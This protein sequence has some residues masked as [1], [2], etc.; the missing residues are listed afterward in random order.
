MVIH[1]LLNNFGNLS[2][3]TELPLLLIFLKFVHRE[4]Q[5]FLYYKTC[6]QVSVGNTPRNIEFR[7]AYGTDGTV[8]LPLRTRN[9][10]TPRNF[11]QPLIEFSLPRLI[12]IDTDSRSILTFSF[13][14]SQTTR[15]S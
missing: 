7:R 8:S 9:F 6:R 15:V 2:Q 5:R 14:P 11:N 10:A 1:S 3:L 4:F 12:P 13:A